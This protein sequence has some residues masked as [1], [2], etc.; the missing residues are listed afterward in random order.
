MGSLS[1]QS[2]LKQLQA[3][4]NREFSENIQPDVGVGQEEAGERGSIMSDNRLMILLHDLFDGG[5]L[6]VVLV[7]CPG[8]GHGRRFRLSSERYEQKGKS[9][10]CE[11]IQFQH[12]FVLNSK[13]MKWF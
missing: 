4:N 8:L 2:L 7:S 3:N 9:T 13:E 5:H 11:V 6:C 10:E 12:Y 1:F